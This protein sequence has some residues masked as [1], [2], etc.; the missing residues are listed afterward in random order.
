MR[1]PP[2]RFTS[3]LFLFAILT[4]A[5]VLAAAATEVGGINRGKRVRVPRTGVQRVTVQRRG[6]ERG[7]A[8][9]DINGAALA[10]GDP[11][12]GDPAAGGPPQA[13]G[14]GAAI[15]AP[16]PPTSHRRQPDSAPVAP[17]SAPAP[18]HVRGRAPPAG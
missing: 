16:A 14:V 11:A 9:G 4:M 2:N 15:T 7:R 6:I 1:P 5:S 18:P 12:V 17:A 8:V 13:A 3:P 10:G